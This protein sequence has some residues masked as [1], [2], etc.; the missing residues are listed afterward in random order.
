MSRP[1]TSRGPYV[2][3]TVYDIKL[4]YEDTAYALHKARQREAK[5]ST[6]TSLTETFKTFSSPAVEVYKDGNNVTK[7]DEKPVES[8]A[9]VVM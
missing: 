3:E 2:A 5:P 9:C 7:V 4:R 8:R 1:K 6:Y